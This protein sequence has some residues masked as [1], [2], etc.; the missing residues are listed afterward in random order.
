MDI[1][2]S[3]SF[4]FVC[5]SDGPRPSQKEIIS[6]RAFMLL[7]LKQLILKV[8]PE[9]CLIIITQPRKKLLYVF[10][11]FPCP[12]W[13]ACRPNLKFECL[14]R[15]LHWKLSESL[16]AFCV[17]VCEC[18]DAAASYASPAW[19]TNCFNKSIWG[20]Q[21]SQVMMDVLLDRIEASRRTSCRAFS[22]TFW[23]CMRW[24][25]L[26]LPERARTDSYRGWVE[27]VESARW[28]VGQS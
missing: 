13:G 8:Q 23:P 22:T 10:C 17:C 18:E 4:A 28:F 12:S 5:W 19:N 3:H 21:Q 6:L 27:F 9:K 15:E 25:S 2:H 11:F 20:R 1:K 16:S 24:G 26:C 7:F 14:F